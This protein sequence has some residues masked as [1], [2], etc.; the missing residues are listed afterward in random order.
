MYIRFWELKC[1]R[2]YDLVIATEENVAGKFQNYLKSPEKVRIIYNYTDLKPGRTVQSSDKKLFDAIY[3]GSI[4]ST[5]GVFEIINAVKLA[6]DR[7]HLLKVL[8]IGPVF[9]KNL[10]KKIY[11]LIQ[12]HQL[13]ENITLK[14][15]VPYS[16]IH[17]YYEASKVGLIIFKDNPVNRIILPIKLFEYMAFGLPVVGSNFGHMK[18]YTEKTNTGLIVN[19]GNPHDICEKLLMLLNDYELYRNLS[20]NGLTAIKNQ[21]N[22]K[23]ME[24]RLLNIYQTLIS[25]NAHQNQ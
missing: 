25:K 17:K 8:F 10:K 9:E 18:A 5:R 14:D 3:S 2:H 16:E 21:Y 23:I 4:R 11:R 12:Y 20:E 19:P 15:P 22:W 1:S 24:D 6:R 7:N 13:N